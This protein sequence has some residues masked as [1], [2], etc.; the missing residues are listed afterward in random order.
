VIGCLAYLLCVQRLM[1]ERNSLKELIEEMRCTQMAP[2][3][4]FP[5]CCNFYH[6]CFNFLLTSFYH[7]F[8]YGDNWLWCVIFFTLKS[9]LERIVVSRAN[10]FRLVLS[11]SPWALSNLTSSFFV[12]LAHCSWLL[13]IAL[14]SCE[15]HACDVYLCQM[16]SYFPKTYVHLTE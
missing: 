2:S 15:T 10:M 16:L 9:R 5:C 6:H 8:G 1:E 12:C 7:W 13:F 3:G 11:N 14:L 4:E